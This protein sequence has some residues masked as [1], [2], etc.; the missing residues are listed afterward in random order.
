MSVKKTSNTTATKQIFG[1]GDNSVK[2][3]A[4]SSGVGEALKKNRL[5]RARVIKSAG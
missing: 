5:I 1:H 2:K 4:A 3:D